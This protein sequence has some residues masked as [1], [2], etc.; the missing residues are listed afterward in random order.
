MRNANHI[1]SG[2]MSSC[3]SKLIAVPNTEVASREQD[4]SSI[5]KDFFFLFL[6]SAEMLLLEQ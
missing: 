3:L 6:H 4:N 5:G 2:H 1:S